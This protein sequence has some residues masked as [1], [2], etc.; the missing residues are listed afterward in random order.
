MAAYQDYPIH[1]YPIHAPP[2]GHSAPPGYAGDDASLDPPP[3]EAPQEPAIV[4]YRDTMIHNP[5]FSGELPKHETVNADIEAI[6][7]VSALKSHAK[8]DACALRVLSM[9]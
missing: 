4:L 1:N 6:L 3:Y 2:A 8:S 7:N 9:R 5:K